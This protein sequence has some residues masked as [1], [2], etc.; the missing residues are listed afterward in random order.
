MMLRP[1]SVSSA[2]DA[3][4][5]PMN[6]RATTSLGCWSCTR[7][8]SSARGFLARMAVDGLGYG[9]ALA[10]ANNTHNY[11]RCARRSVSASENS[12]CDALYTICAYVRTRLK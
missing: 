4:M 6:T 7:L 5:D 2:K 9:A 1:S 10:K 12:V 11:A 3:W 8:A